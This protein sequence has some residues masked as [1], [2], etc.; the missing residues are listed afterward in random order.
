MHG[1]KAGELIREFA[2]GEKWQIQ[3]FNSNL[4][5][6][7]IEDCGI[8]HHMFQSLIRKM[9][10]EGLDVQSTRNPD[11][12]GALI[13]H[14]SL[15]RSK[16]CLMAYV[17]NR[18]EIIR[19]LAWKVGLKLFELPE[20]I[21]EKFSHTEKTYFEQHAKALETY[22]NELALDLNVDMVPPKDPYIKVRVLD[23]V[24]DD[25]IL[26]DKAAKLARHSMHFLKRT[27]AEPFIARVGC[28]TIHP[29]GSINLFVVAGTAPRHSRRWASTISSFASCIC[30]FLIFLQLP[31]FR[32]PCRSGICTTPLEVTSSELIASELFPA[33]VVKALLY[34][35]AIANAI[36]NYK[37]FPSYKDLIKLY[38]LT[39][40][41]KAPTT[42]DLQ[43]LE[44]LAGSY[45]C[46]AGALLGLIK[47][48]RM[49]LFGTL[50]VLWGLAREVIIKKP[51]D[52]I[53]SKAIHIYPTM[54]I[55]VV[56][57]FLSIR[58]DVRK[59]IHS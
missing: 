31:L 27:D 24:G 37:S 32:V 2:G 35:G 43:R 38:N 28:E 9:H 14:L 56:C 46:V 13:H 48:G 57:A 11:H 49:S 55:A 47:P 52:S 29:L 1:K 45:L 42:T 15:I 50:L 8:N 12:Y 54:L 18:A 16:R 33:F 3:S 53:F 6:E 10:E 19:N 7:I 5:D 20:E 51:A 21:Q 59:I 23:D 40:V 30:F 39:N 41:R 58:R 34:P 36:F 25:I 26:S 22:M 44:V 4:F 17:Y